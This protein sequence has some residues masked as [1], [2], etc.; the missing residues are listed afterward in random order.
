MLPIII[1][2]KYFAPA[3]ETEDNKLLIS[4]S[5]IAELPL[6]KLGDFFKTF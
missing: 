2:V 1:L 3:G 4:L 6:L 5:F